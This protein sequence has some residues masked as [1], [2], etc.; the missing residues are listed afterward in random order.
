MGQLIIDCADDGTKTLCNMFST[1][2]PP[3]MTL[4]SNIADFIDW[5]DKQCPERAGVA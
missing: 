5:L 2:W 1:N 4:A 3:P